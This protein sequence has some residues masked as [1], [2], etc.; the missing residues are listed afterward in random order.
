MAAGVIREAQA[1][2]LSKPRH[3]PMP[4]TEL[5]IEGLRTIEKLRLR[6][7]GLTVLIGENGSGKSSIIEACELLRRATSERFLDELYSIHGGLPGLLRQGAPHLRLGVTLGPSSWRGHR[8]SSVDYDLTLS[9]A[10][11]F[12]SLQE[13]VSYKP[14]K[15]SSARTG[16][17]QR[18]SHGSKRSTGSKPS[19]L[20]VR[21]Q[22]DVYELYEGDSGTV[23]SGDIP[24]DKTLL[25][26]TELYSPDST[27]DDA[28]KV[29]TAALREI[30]V[31]L[32]FEVT[33][34]WA[35]RALDRKSAMR[36]PSPLAPA[37]RLEK[38]G[39]NLANAFHALKNNYSQ[40]E[41]QRTLGYLRLGLGE[42]IEDVA[43]LADPG[44]GSI[45]LS[46]KL[47]NLDRQIPASQLSD[48]MLSYLAY[49]ALF[50][51]RA[52]PPALVALDEPDLHLHP[53]LLMRVLDMFE[54][55]ARDFPV[56]VATHSDR[57]L[58]GLS[59]PARAVVLCE[60]DEN[61]ATRLYRPDPNALSKWL[62]RY[63]GLGDIRGAGHEASVLTRK[64][65]A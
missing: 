32:P 3:A 57:L 5:R 53:R 45:S 35:A 55:M 54:A 48:G 33:P 7:D 20:A 40:E 59:D 27:G 63:R 25:S 58:D 15:A 29:V 31:H 51:L 36:I 43:T 42:D 12:A 50:R 60:L 28:V 23:D 52:T 49:V 19:V 8:Y 4:I 56:L 44:G 9:P 26:Q 18:S 39:I 38:L 17:A 34:A 46:L 16:A 61:R 65:R 14:R 10:G 22:V 11:S 24:I 41:W 13:E 6:L 62:E 21:R 30:H 37:G 2:F 47:K 64:E 1:V